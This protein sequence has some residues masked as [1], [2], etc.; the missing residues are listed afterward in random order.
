MLQTSVRSS[1]S[2]QETTATTHW[3]SMA[4]LCRTTWIQT[5]HTRKQSIDISCQ[6]G[7]QQQICSSGFAAVGW[8]WDRQ[9]E[10]CKS[11]YVPKVISDSHRYRSSMPMV[12][13][14][15]QSM[16][17]YYS[18]IVTISLGGTAV[19]AIKVSKTVL[20]NKN[21]RKDIYRAA[22]VMQSS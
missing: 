2:L 8:C 22:S 12:A 3:S 18:S 17:S 19:K 16:T 20:P 1:A 7:P 6:P 13:T 10:R 11:Q 9:S 15:W 21:D 5:H 14:D 4:A